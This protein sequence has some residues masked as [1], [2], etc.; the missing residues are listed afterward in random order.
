MPWVPCPPPPPLHNVDTQFCAHAH[1]FNL[2]G[3]H[4]NLGESRWNTAS[5]TNSQYLT[6]LRSPDCR[7][8]CIR[9]NTNSNS[10]DNP[11][12]NIVRV[13][14]GYFHRGPGAGDHGYP[15]SDDF[16]DNDPV[17]YDD[18]IL[19]FLRWWVPGAVNAPW[20]SY[21]RGRILRRH[22]GNCKHICTYKIIS[23]LWIF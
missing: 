18:S 4:I 6:I 19:I 11:G 5:M 2:A 15:A 23:I 9:P 22:G 20:G 17:L 10:C 12:I 13:E 14:G 7:G 1:Y 21:S 3:S 16:R 8:W